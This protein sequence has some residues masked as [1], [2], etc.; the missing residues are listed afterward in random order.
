MILFWKKRGDAN[1]SPAKALKRECE[2]F[3]NL[4]G[5]TTKIMQIFKGREDFHSQKVHF[6]GG[7]LLA[8]CSFC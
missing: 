4:L 3:L 2:K 6:G 5:S 8:P 1:S 7:F